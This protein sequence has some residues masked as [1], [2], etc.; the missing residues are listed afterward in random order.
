MND[1]ETPTKDLLGLGPYG[2]TL[3]VLAE[4]AVTFLSRICGPAADEFG[5]ILRDKVH[6]WR[7]KNTV[8]II[9]KAEDLLHAAAEGENRMAHPRIV[10]GIIEEGSWTDSASVQELWAG[11]LASSCTPDG[12]DESNL[13]FV[14]LL[15]QLSSSQVRILQYAC[16]N[17]TKE[18]TDAGW[19]HAQLVNCT[20]HKLQ[21]LSGVSD[22]HRLD[23]EMDH[24]ASLGLLS[25][26][27]GFD[28]Y[29]K[30]ATAYIT[31]SPLAL[32]LYVRCTGSLD[33][34]VTFFGLMRGQPNGDASS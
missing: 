19:I 26:G 23:R 28:A 14:N 20:L 24:L 2:E 16:Q 9:L 34:P 8:R 13:L 32:H 11:L 27:G 3:K 5:L 18:V 7:L 1:P 30:N 17:A 4:G 25:G 31:P 12:T 6:L 15:A 29:D 10:W 22:P 21:D 33:D